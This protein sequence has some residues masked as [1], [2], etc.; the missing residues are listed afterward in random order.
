MR[1]HSTDSLHAVNLEEL[2]LCPEQRQ[3]HVDAS[4]WCVGWKP[5]RR[6]VANG[7]SAG[8]PVGFWHPSQSQARVELIRS[9][10]RADR[11]LLQGWLCLQVVRHGAGILA[12]PCLRRSNKT[13]D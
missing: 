9:L 3:R 1:L 13:P 7:P 11:P 6:K 8:A 12:G 10:D 2:E 4:Q 5:A